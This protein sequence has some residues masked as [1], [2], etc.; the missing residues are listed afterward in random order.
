M[1]EEMQLI[2][3]NE[4]ELDEILRLEEIIINQAFICLIPKNNNPSTPN[5]YRLISSLLF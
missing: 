2:K 5:N 1:K 3:A 4:E